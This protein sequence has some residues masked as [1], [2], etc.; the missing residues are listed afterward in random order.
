MCWRLARRLTDILRL[1]WPS[2]YQG[3][4][5]WGFCFHS[6]VQKEKWHHVLTPSNN[7]LHQRRNHP[8]QMSSRRQQA[9]CVIKRG[10]NETLDSEPF[11]T[12]RTTQEEPSVQTSISS[13]PS[14]Q[15]VRA[16]WQQAP[17]VPS[18]GL[19]VPAVMRR[20]WPGKHCEA[21]GRESSSRCFQVPPKFWGW[22]W[23]LVS[24]TCQ[25]KWA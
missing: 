18:S 12:V 23:Q 7:L 20:T 2:V 22:D 1:E 19:I 15:H 11:S 25:S 21:I 9:R 10:G 17:A 14:E 5:Q 24:V 4:N 8:I 16:A 13:S 3:Q 6:F